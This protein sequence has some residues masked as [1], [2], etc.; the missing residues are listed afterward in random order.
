MLRLRLRRLWGGR[1][2][3]DR[4]ERAGHA[5]LECCHEDAHPRHHG[6]LEV[7]LRTLEVDQLGLLAVELLGDLL[8]GRVRVG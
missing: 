8:R 7:L 3:R 2:G 6:A 5:R 4:L 1:L